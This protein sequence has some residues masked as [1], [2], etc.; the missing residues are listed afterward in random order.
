MPDG[1]QIKDVAETV[2]GIVEAVPVYQDVVQPAARQVGTA[3][4]T[5]AKTI[6]IA[7]APIS[8]LVWGYEQIKD[9]VSTKVAEKLSGVPDEKIQ[10]P[11]P[12]VA[13][14]AL[15]ALKYTGHKEDL[16]ELYANL[17]ANA[18]NI[19]TAKSAHPGFVDIIRN[20]TSDEARVLIFLAS[21]RAYPIISTKAILK[22]GTG[23]Q[24]LMENVSMLGTD[25][26]CQNPG[27]TP[28]YIDNL[29]R[30]GLLVIP[31][32][33]HL[34]AVGLYDAITTHPAVQKQ[35]AQI[36]QDKEKFSGFDID[37]KYIKLTAFGLMFAEACIYPPRTPQQ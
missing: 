28:K 9:F 1:N 33:E 20:L 2:K 25:A 11:D 7:L 16:R 30:L 8:A 10:T 35:K 18:I 13:G 22:D 15:E 14:P 23:E 27:F 32:L 21:R 24:R 37:K 36:E 26:G 3:L 4:E 19:D 34:T 17:L 29:I 6:H 5:V 12:T 31:P